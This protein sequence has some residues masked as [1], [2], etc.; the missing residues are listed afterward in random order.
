M[1]WQAAAR[2][3]HVAS[4]SPLDQE[5]VHAR[6]L[7]RAASRLKCVTDAA[8]NGA[9]V[10]KTD[11]RLVR[12][13]LVF[14]FMPSRLRAVKPRIQQQV[15]RT[16]LR[17]RSGCEAEE[18]QVSRTL[19]W[20]LSMR[21]KKASMLRKLTTQFPSMVAH[22]PP[23]GHPGSEFAPAGV[24]DAALECAANLKGAGPGLGA[25]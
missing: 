21:L 23:P 12:L 18:L 14:K 7:V 11:H 24:L 6:P 20:T 22:T 8:V 5:A 13:D 4:S 2:L 19:W 25:P 1:W 17:R 15:D 9:G 16:I 10:P 3:R